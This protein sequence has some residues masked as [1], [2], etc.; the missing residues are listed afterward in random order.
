MKTN[1]FSAIIISL[2]IVSCSTGKSST[3]TDKQSEN[4][5]VL[6]DLSD[7]LLNDKQAEQDI[8]LIYHI[9]EQYESIVRNNLII[10]SKDKFR[11]VMAPQEKM[12]I[13]RSL[14]ESMFY[15]DMSKI[16]IAE[17]RNELEKFKKDLKGNLNNLY[18]EAMRNKTKTS[19]FQGA[20]IWKY[21]NDYLS[22]DIE[23]ENKNRLFILSDGYFD[24]ESASVK[25][26]MGGK[27]TSSAFLSLV[28]GKTNWQKLIENKGY[29]I[30]PV[31]KQFDS[32]SVCLMEIY[33]KY[34]N[35]DETDMIQFVWKQW[36]CEMNIKEIGFMPHASIPKM[37]GQI[38]NFLSKSKETICD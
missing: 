29:G 7:R 20:D 5:I 38:D 36:L 13:N 1:L 2:F 18:A 15:L 31:N 10:N 22:G 16:Q 27:S 35:L 11:I 34:A 17:K 19:D 21:F 24:F 30:I 25:K 37:E 3:A 14:S 12:A 28:R 23:Q 4:Y 9:F 26:N 6:L 8:E 33:P 32:L